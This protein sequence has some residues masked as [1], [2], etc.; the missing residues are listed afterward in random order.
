MTKK[1]ISKT[2]TFHIKV[3][4]EVYTTL[5]AQAEKNGASLHGYANRILFEKAESLKK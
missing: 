5:M 1:H 2:V 4:R 3:P